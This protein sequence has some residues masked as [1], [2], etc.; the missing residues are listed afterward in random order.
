MIKKNFEIAKKKLKI[1]SYQEAEILL[2]EIIIED[3]N[4]FG[5]HF[6]LGSLYGLLNKVEM[7]LKYLYLAKDIDSSNFNTYFNI[8]LIYKKKKEP[9]KAKIY[10]EKALDIE[11]KHVGSLCALGQ[12]YEEENNLKKAKNEY[13]KAV[14]YEST[15]KLACQLYGKILL[16]LNEHKKGLKYMKIGSGFIRFTNQKIEMI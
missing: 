5:S 15:N 11:V 2:K 6:L 16:K 3:P 13:E 14:N 8:G 10:L 1:K 12:L 9:T 4:H 7:A